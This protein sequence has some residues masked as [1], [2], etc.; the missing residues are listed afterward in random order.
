MEML[1]NSINWFE[2]PVADFERARDFYSAIYDFD[3]PTADMGPNKLGFFLV[4]RGGI[5]GA[6]A[7]GPGYV[8]TKQ[9]TL[10]YLNGGEDLSVVLDRVPGA[11][12]RIEMPKT[13]ITPDLG[14]MAIIEDTEGNR[15]ALHSMK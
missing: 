4:E 11:G 6:I 9:G 3:M 10:V 8:P 15:V 14:F 13:Q 5:G 12:G 7:M 2:I 1:K